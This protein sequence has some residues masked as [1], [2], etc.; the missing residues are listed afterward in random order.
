MPKISIGHV[1]RRHDVEIQRNS[2]KSMHVKIS[3]S[4]RS[5][6]HPEDPGLTPPREDS[7]PQE[8]GISPSPARE[9]PPQ[10]EESHPHKERNKRC[11][12][13]FL[14]RTASTREKSHPLE[15]RKSNENEWMKLSRHPHYAICPPSVSAAACESEV[16]ST[17]RQMT[18]SK[19]E[20]NK[21]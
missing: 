2:Q 16:A 4:Q 18:S 11:P 1:P 9:M 13:R 20:T 3:P 21:V 19:N 6:P 8:R 7:H 17:S 10:M 5:H 15:E 14:A 12:P